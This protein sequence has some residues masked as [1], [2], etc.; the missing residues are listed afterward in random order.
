MLR[1]PRRGLFLTYWPR[2]NDD[3]LTR[4]IVERELQ[5]ET[6][7]TDVQQIIS[8]DVVKLCHRLQRNMWPKEGASGSSSK[9]ILTLAFVLQSSGTSWAVH[10]CKLNYIC[11]LNNKPNAKRR[12]SRQ[13]WHSFNRL[14]KDENPEE[15]GQTYQH[16]PKPFV[17]CVFP[18]CWQEATRGKPSSYLKVGLWEA[19]R[20]EKKHPPM[21]RTT[22]SG[23]AQVCFQVE[24]EEHSVVL[25]IC[26]DG[27]DYFYSFLHSKKKKEANYNS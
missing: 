21:E 20:E 24:E 15:H 26:C 9:V 22:L 25:F 10:G 2:L 12:C 17:Y 1:T 7:C 4:A 5:T 13:Q 19:T 6:W 8:Y 18:L 16:H 14:P 27:A 23:G 11:G 3:A